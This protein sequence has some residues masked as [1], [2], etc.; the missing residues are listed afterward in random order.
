MDAKI[1]IMDEPS[2]SLNETELGA[3]FEVIRELV[4]Q[5]VAILYV[6]HRLGEL[7]EIGDRVTVLRSGRTIDTFEVKSTPDSV[8]LVRRSSAR[9]A[10]WSSAPRAAV[11]GG[12][13]SGST[14]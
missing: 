6:S 10:R 13:R 8:R 4:R 3:V 14:G 11:T 2:A 7:R 1:I 9:S 12:R 5:G